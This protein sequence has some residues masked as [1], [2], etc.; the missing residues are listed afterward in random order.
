MFDPNKFKKSVK[1]WVR[2]HSEGTI[3]EFVDFCEEQIPPSHFAANRWLIDQSVSWYRH[4]LTQRKASREL[5]NPDF[6]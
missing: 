4:I 5:D 1:E 6:I 2:S 3:S